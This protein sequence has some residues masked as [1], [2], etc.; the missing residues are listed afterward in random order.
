MEVIYMVDKHFLKLQ[1]SH[2][3][4][5]DELQLKVTQSDT[6]FLEIFNQLCCDFKYIN[7]ITQSN[8]RAQTIISNFHLSN[9]TVIVL[10]TLRGTSIIR[11]LIHKY[12][13][14]NLP[15]LFILDSNCKINDVIKNYISTF[16][17]VKLVQI[18][19]LK[20]TLSRY[21]I[22][23]PLILNPN[24]LVYFEDDPT[25]AELTVD[26][27]ILF[28]T[29]SVVH[30]LLLCILFTNR[31]KDES[32]L[33]IKLTNIVKYVYPQIN[34]NQLN[35]TNFLYDLIKSG[36]ISKKLEIPS[37]LVPHVKR[38][39][40]IK[41]SHCKELVNYLRH[42]QFQNFENIRPIYHTRTP[43][44]LLR[45]RYLQTLKP[46]SKIFRNNNPSGLMWKLNRTQFKK[47]SYY[48]IFDCLS[49]LKA[50]FIHHG[51]SKM[52]K[53]FVIKNLPIFQ[54]NTK[55][56]RD[57]HFIFKHSHIF[58]S[59][60]IKSRIYICYLHTHELPSECEILDKINKLLKC[61]FICISFNYR[62][63]AYTH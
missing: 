30:K 7:V 22:N 2:T 45:K 61:L 39:I 5:E 26:L 43:Y 53:S 3:F 44:H 20:H 4:I 35:S 51:K 37:I 41:S 59:V 40:A 12:K 9:C 52:L 48:S 57:Y 15:Y 14:R 6:D 56:Y 60:N 11:D 31:L 63:T 58:Q 42:R 1:T 24:E 29:I 54:V 13:S 19:K 36:L 38:H 25:N 50:L 46:L 32:Y 62:A 33:Q 8:L 28:S 34:I 27:S 16:D 18:S 55:I 47:T 10:T 23:N 21:S 17:T 49:T